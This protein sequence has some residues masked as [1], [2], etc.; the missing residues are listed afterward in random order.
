VFETALLPNNRELG[1]HLVKHGDGVKDVAFEVDNL[2]WILETAKKNG[3]TVV[4]ELKIEKDDDGFVKTASLQ[5]YGDTIH[6]LVERKHYKGMFLPGFKPH[7]APVDFY[8]TL[9]PVGL[10]FLG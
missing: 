5:T 9:P 8:K 3:A 1:D 6:T 7:P 4:H 10:D 2:E